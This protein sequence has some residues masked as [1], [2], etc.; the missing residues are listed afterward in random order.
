MSCSQ[1]SSSG[2]LAD[3]QQLSA[4]DHPQEFTLQ[5]AARKEVGSGK[6][7]PAGGEGPAFSLCRCDAIVIKITLSFHE[8]THSQTLSKKVQE[9]KRIPRVKGRTSFKSVPIEPG[10]DIVC[11]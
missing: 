2:M 7:H 5:P 9:F 8:F 6:E 1:I 11:C 3:T 10:N 4:F